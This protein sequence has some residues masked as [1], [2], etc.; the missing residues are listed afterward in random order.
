MNYIDTVNE[1]IKEYF[2]VLESDFPDWLNQYINTPSLLKQQYISVTCGTFYS[3][4]FSN[5]VFFS[6]LD[7][8]IAVAL[9]CWHYTHD[10]KATLA[11]LFH[12]VATPVFK[13][14]IDFMNGDYINQ[15]S[16]EERTREIIENDAEVMR[17]LKRDNI[18]VDEIYDYKMYP[19]ADNDTPRLSAD[20]FEYSLSNM[21]FTYGLENLDTVKNI[22]NS[23]T[24]DFVNED[25]IIELGFEDVILARKFVEITSKL[26]IIYR[27]DR[28]IYSMQLLADILKSLSNDGEITASDLYNMKEEEVIELIKNS[29]YGSLFEIWA[30]S[31]KV[32]LSKEKP[33]GVYSVNHPSKVRF[34]DPLV[35]NKSEVGRSSKVD[36]YSKSFIDANMVYNLNEYVYLPGLSFDN[37]KKLG[38]VKKLS[39]R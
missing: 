10:K 29:K 5:R 8:S 2:S 36:E 4:L 25:G 1:E 27:E 11:G 35:R 9:I 20:R 28:T 19:I 13:H 24:S 14:S 15:E 3:D 23:V 26:S 38:P 18:S 7:H 22:Y 32:L 34:I 39:R 16:T 37:I 31:K 33:E 6:S 17:L 30:S 12:D 21:Y